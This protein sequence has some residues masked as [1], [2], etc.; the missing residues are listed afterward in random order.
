MTNKEQAMMTM[1]IAL[2]KYLQDND[3]AYAGNDDFIAEVADF[4]VVYNINKNAAVAAHVDNKGFSAEKQTQKSI[5]ANTAS[6]LCG[7][8]FVKLKKAGKLSIA[9]QLHKEP[10]DYLQVADSLCG[11]NA[12][13]SHDIMVANITD[14]G[15]NT[16]TLPML[17]GL[18]NHIDKFIA[19]QGSSETVHEVS[20]ALTKQFK[21]SFAP[22]MD[23]IDNLKYWNRDYK[24][25]NNEFYTGLLASTVIPAI[26]IHHTYVYINA[27]RKS[28]NKPV[29]G[30]TFTLTKGKKSAVTDSD[31]NANIEEV[32]AGKDTLTGVLS[33]NVIHTSNITIKRGTTNHYDLIID[34]L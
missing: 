17:V 18:Q 2:A 34:S 12:Q 25:S 24:S 20:P 30:A 15:P 28:N 16:I 8:A 26:N 6:N 4:L 29:E 1:F 19:I 13:S 31:G 21:E 10:S 33:G 7:K 22:V 14:L 5:L 27:L 32:K 23:I 11:T 9:E 3:Q